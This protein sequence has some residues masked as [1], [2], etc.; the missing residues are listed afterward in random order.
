MKSWLFAFICTAAF[1]GT[2]HASDL[3]FGTVDTIKCSG[4]NID[5]GTGSDPFVVDWN[6]DGLKDLIVGQF[7]DQSG[8]NYGKIRVY[9]NQG[10]D[11]DPIFNSWFYMQ[12]DGSDIASDAG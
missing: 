10:T 5:V 1:V 2:L 7:Y 9:L 4:V 8:N 3:T 11:S 12:A 6:G